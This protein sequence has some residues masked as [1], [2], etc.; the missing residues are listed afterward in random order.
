M[1]DGDKKYELLPWPNFNSIQGGYGGV[2]AEILLGPDMPRNFVEMPNPDNPRGL[3]NLFSVIKE[4]EKKKISMT[5]GSKEGSKLISDRHEYSILGAYIG[6]DGRKYVRL[7]NP[8][9]SSV[10]T[11]GLITTYDK[12]GKASHKWTNVPDGI[13]DIEISDFAKEMDRMDVNGFGKSETKVKIQGHTKGRTN[14]R[15]ADISLINSK[16]KLYTFLIGYALSG[17]NVPLVNYNLDDMQFN[18]ASDKILE[19]FE[20][21]ALDKGITKA[22]FESQKKGF[23]TL[24]GDIQ[25]FFDDAFEKYW[26]EKNVT[27]PDNTVEDIGVVRKFIDNIG[28]SLRSELNKHQDKVPNNDDKSLDAFGAKFFNKLY[29]SM[30]II[31]KDIKNNFEIVKDAS[32]IEEG[33]NHL[34]EILNK[35]KNDPNQKLY[36]DSISDTRNLQNGIVISTGTERI[37]VTDVF[38]DEKGMMKAEIESV[39]GKNVVPFN[40]IFVH[41]KEFI[42][43]DT[44]PEVLKG[45]VK[46]GEEILAE[47]PAGPEKEKPKDATT[48]VPDYKSLREYIKVLDDVDSVL[49]ASRSFGDRSSDQFFN[50]QKGLKDIRKA[51]VFDNGKPFKDLG[52]TL[53]KM[54][55]QISE[56]EKHCQESPRSGWRRSTRVKACDMLKN[57]ISAA[58]KGQEEPRAEIEFDYTKKLISRIY[59]KNGKQVP[60]GKLDVLAQNMMKEQHFNA[61]LKNQNTFKMKDPTDKELNN[62]IAKLQ[63]SEERYLEKGGKK[64][65]QTVMN[66]A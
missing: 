38:K 17:L 45:L 30:A 49:A 57:L 27:G 40:T 5:A 8:W 55:Q 11:N 52:E 31:T 63:K 7:R 15:I 9:G 13:F 25:K 47:N 1:G 29:S 26:D 39:A 20:K 18:N 36:I 56:Y 54:N 62:S 14:E 48:V 65:E 46:P 23:E 58:Q 12:D 24:A 41:A 33:F 34:S 22:E 59:A 28:P 42:L 50:I 37:S 2:A 32:N 10:L 43:S 19:V 4:G 51:V 44:R 66:M 61:F 64:F 53:S 3:D 35:I 16:E 21:A 6:D 60:E